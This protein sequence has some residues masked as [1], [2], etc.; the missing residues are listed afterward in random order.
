MRQYLWQISH[1]TL[2]FHITFAIVT[3]FVR[4][5]YFYFSQRRTSMN[6]TGVVAIVVSDS[7]SVP[8]VQTALTNHGSIICGRMGIPDHESGKNVIA[9]IV[10]GTVEQISALTGALVASP[11]SKPKACLLKSR[12]CSQVLLAFWRQKFCVDNDVLLGHR[13]SR[14][15]PSQQRRSYLPFARQTTMLANYHL[16]ANPWLAHN[17]YALFGGKLTAQSSTFSSVKDFPSIIPRN[18]VVLACLFL[19]K[20]LR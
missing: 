19:T 15:V 3:L 6:R 8:Q 11:A 13:P 9:L 4:E 1:V 14:Y 7:N 17:V 18:N 12:V 20:S 5:G 10:K 16:F 2:Q